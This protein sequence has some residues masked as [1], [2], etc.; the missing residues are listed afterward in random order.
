MSGILSRCVL[1]I[2]APRIY[3][4][5]LISTLEACEAAG[6]ELVLGDLKH[7]SVCCEEL[8]R[9]GEYITQ[10]H[11]VSR[12]L[13]TSALINYRRCFNSGCRVSIKIEECNFLS[14][15]DREHHRD[16]INLA[17][18]HLAHSVNGFERANMTIHI[19][20]DEDKGSLTR[21]GV[22]F[23]SSLGMGFGL[24]DIQQLASLVEKIEG[25]FVQPR[26]KKLKMLVEQQIAQMSDDEFRVLPDGLAHGLMGDVNK[27]RSHPYQSGG[28]R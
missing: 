2:M 28:K 27:A 11:D 1:L 19:A 6:F 18:K 20:E 14:A 13:F 17:D 9:R 4:P 22:G 25:G 5:K 3:Q 21:S 8:I 15:E 7:V 26:I 12:A 16:C 24:N 10:F 23:A